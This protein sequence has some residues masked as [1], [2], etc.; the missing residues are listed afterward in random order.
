MQI[1]S[2]PGIHKSKGKRELQNLFTAEGGEEARSQRSNKVSLVRSLLLDLLQFQ[3]PAAEQMRE[4]REAA[5]GCCSAAAQ[6]EIAIRL[7][8]RAGG[9]HAALQAR[10]G[11]G[12]RLRCSSRAV[13][14]Q[15]SAFV[16]KPA[17]H[18]ESLAFELF[19]PARF[20][21]LAIVHAERYVFFRFFS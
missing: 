13:R 9:A 8:E 16:D 6:D 18:D 5:A 2:S 3:V 4:E 17:D 1:Q 21:V 20:V 14:G 10:K 19:V 15:F 12:V 11:A 7:A